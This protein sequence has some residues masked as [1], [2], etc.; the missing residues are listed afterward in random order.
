MRPNITQTVIKLEK[1]Q[2]KNKSE[3]LWTYHDKKRSRQADIVNLTWKSVTISPVIQKFINLGWKE[4]GGKKNYLVI[5]G[6]CSPQI[7]AVTKPCDDRCNLE[8]N[9]QRYHVRL[10]ILGSDVVGSA[11]IDKR[12]WLLSTQFEDI[13]QCH[14]L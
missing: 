14:M 1:T 6:I 7:S 5:S 11:H 8:S 10:W 9:E 4:S 2:I 3:L 13:K 12:L